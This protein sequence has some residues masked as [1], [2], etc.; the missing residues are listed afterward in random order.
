MESSTIR[1]ISSP[2]IGGGG[3]GAF[4]VNSTNNLVDTAPVLNICNGVNTGKNGPKY[5]FH[6]S[7]SFNRSNRNQNSLSF[8]GG[9]IIKGW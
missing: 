9:C 5:S 8:G 7:I 1:S 3:A 4:P 6:K 2:T